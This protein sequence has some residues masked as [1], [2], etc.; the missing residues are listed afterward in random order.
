[1]PDRRQNKNE[2]KIRRLQKRHTRIPR[3]EGT[4]PKD[5]LQ[6]TEQY[7]LYTSS[8]PA[9]ALLRIRNN[10]STGRTAINP[11]PALPVWAVSMIARAIS[12]ALDLS[13]KISIR[14]G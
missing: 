11:S 3:I 13:V 7:S 6:S 4:L 14:C 10:F 5:I 12:S 9:S 2:W 8:I 1:V